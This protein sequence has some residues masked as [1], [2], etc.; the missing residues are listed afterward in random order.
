MTVWE[1]KIIDAFISRY[2]ASAP[3][4]GEDRSVL[5]I[6]SSKLFPDFDEVSS[7]EK[8]SYLEAAESLEQKGI[9]K[10][11]WEKWNK[12]NRLKT[13]SC[14]NFEKLFEEAGRPVPK[15][16]A[17]Q[18]RD[19]LRPGCGALL[20]YL[21]RNFGPREIGQGINK[22]TME[23]LVRLLEFCSVPE[24]IEKITTRA[25][26]ILLYRDSKHLENL[27]D[28]C[29]P[30]LS[31]AAKTVS[32]PD[33]SFLERSYPETMISGKITIKY[34]NGQTL[35]VNSEGHILGIPLENAEEI[36]SIQLCNTNE[37]AAKTVLTIEN[38]ETFYALGTPQNYRSEKLSR[39][40]CFLY[41]GGYL[42]RAA[43]ALVKA[44][45]SSGFS[46]YH[47][48]DLDPDGILILQQIKSIA[49]KPVTPVR[50]D[51]ATFDQYRSWARTLAR[52]ILAQIRKISDETRAIPELAGLIRRIEETSLGVE[53]EIIDYR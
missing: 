41:I 20:E 17:G 40:D 29:K 14:E 43:S 31:R 44:L 49:G 9:I 35:L 36:K 11:S 48:G 27:L 38:K 47:A 10:L 2:F 4:A 22:Q 46:F 1:R 19:M 6:R 52:P 34:K 25:L 53:Q 16:E 7:D 51:A 26:S 13:L 15:T 3:A 50:M 21:S 12:G 30:L 32:V 5:R 23:D 28:L 37:P 45:A 39:Y 24:Q 33:F 8:S 42:N 18:I